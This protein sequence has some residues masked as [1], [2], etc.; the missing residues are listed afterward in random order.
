MRSIY[1]KRLHRILYIEK[2]RNWIL[3]TDNTY[4]YGEVER[5]IKTMKNFKVANLEDNLCLTDC[6]N[7]AL[8][9]MRFTKHT[10]LKLTPFESQHG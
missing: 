4:R 1:L 6:V 7:R 2:H 3:H 5:A 8:K 9:V 10:G